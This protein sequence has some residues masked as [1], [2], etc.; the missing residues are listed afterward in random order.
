MYPAQFR[1]IAKLSNSSPTT[2]L[3]TMYSLVALLSKAIFQVPRSENDDDDSDYK[4]KDGKGDMGD[5][6]DDDNGDYEAEDE[7]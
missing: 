2:L 1:R 5:D 3:R 7:I 6:E 4:T